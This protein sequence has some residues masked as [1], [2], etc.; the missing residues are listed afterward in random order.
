MKLAFIIRGEEQFKVPGFD[1]SSCL[2]SEVC[3]V[4][5]ELFYTHYQ[6]P[7]IF[8][9]LKLHAFYFTDNEQ[10]NPPKVKAFTTRKPHE[11]F[12]L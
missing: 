10:K 4:R 11:L 2:F 3:T 1:R 8:F 7:W 6:K 9:F 5:V 12:Y